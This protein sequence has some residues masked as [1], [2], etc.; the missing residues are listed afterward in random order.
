M[1][2][3]RIENLKVYAHHGVLEEEKQNGQYFFLNLTM[4]LSLQG[5]GLRDALE[6][7][8]DYGEVC[9]FLIE[10][11]QGQTWDLIESAAENISAALFRHFPVIHKLTLEIRKPEA[12]IKAQFESVSV[13]IRRKRHR[14]FIGYGANM[15][16]PEHKIESGIADIEHDPMC[17]VLSMSSMFRSTPYGGVE[18]NDFYNGV[19]EV[20]TLYEPYELLRFLQGV[21]K[22]HGLDRDKKIHW[23]P[24]P[25][26]LDILF[27]DDLVMNDKD[28]I[29]PH[30]DLCRRDFVLVP[31]AQIAPNLRHPILG[32][33][34]REL[35]GELKERHI[36]ED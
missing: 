36:R 34:I 2:E 4:G 26:D 14:V 22:A 35:E 31:L 16:E 17:R 9:G 25:L 33:T 7:T 18:Q 27:Y 20:A 32:K 8:V 5:A 12:P 10:K 30:A 1:D 11:M 24:R 21:E 13:V 6:E 19:I 3:I 29:L 15:D 23:G 28:L